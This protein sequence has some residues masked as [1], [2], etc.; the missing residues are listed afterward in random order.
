MSTCNDYITKTTQAI[1]DIMTESPVEYTIRVIKYLN[2]NNAILNKTNVQLVTT[3]RTQ[4]SKKNKRTLDKARLLSK[5]TADVKRTEVE[6]K[7]TADIVHKVAIGQKKKEQMLKKT[8]EKTD[9]TERTIQ[10]AAAK[11]A[12]EINIEMSRL[13]KIKQRLFT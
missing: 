3:A 2:V 10:R 9:K 6:V 11:D 8:K 12:R 13:A 1:K 7:K 5:E 4:Q